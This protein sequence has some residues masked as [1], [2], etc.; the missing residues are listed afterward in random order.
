LPHRQLKEE[1]CKKLEQEGKHYITEA[2]FVTGGRAD[3]LVL[4]D[5]K[6]IEIVKTESDESIAKKKTT[7]PN[8]L[9]IEV[10]RC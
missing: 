1:I 5:F 9:K 2:I 7:Y 3:I 6:A 10:I 8:G 4:D